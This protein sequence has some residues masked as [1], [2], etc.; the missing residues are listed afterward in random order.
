MFYACNR[1]GKNELSKIPDTL[2]K[3][4]T[5]RFCGSH[6]ISDKGILGEETSFGEDDINT[7]DQ[8]EN[9]APSNRNTPSNKDTDDIDL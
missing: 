5:A 1:L 6:C 8:L 9:D 4:T 7:R 2:N 3:E